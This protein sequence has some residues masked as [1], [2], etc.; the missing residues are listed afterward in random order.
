MNKHVSKFPRWH[1]SF[2]SK[3]TIDDFET[4]ALYQNTPLCC[5]FFFLFSISTFLVFWDFEKSRENVKAT[6]PRFLSMP[7]EINVFE[8]VSLYLWLDFMESIVDAPVCM[9]KYVDL[10]AIVLRD[11][12]AFNLSDALTQVIWFQ[13][14]LFN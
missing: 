8:H 10:I 5:C 2:R 6:N 1:N 13:I 3:I 11:R 14:K 4:M 7:L 9:E 12:P